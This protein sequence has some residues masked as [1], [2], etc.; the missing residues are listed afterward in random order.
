MGFQK[1]YIPWNKNM[2][3]YTNSGSFKK[4]NIPWN[5]GKKLPNWIRKKFSKSAIGKH[6]REKNPRWKG[7]RT[8]RNGY[9]YLLM[10]KHPFCDTL[11]YYAEHR[12]VIE[13]KLKR[14]LKSNEHTHHINGIKNDNRIENLMLFIS[15]SAHK[16]FEIN[17]IVKPKEIIFNGCQF[18]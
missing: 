16:R 18:Q 5:K 7:G 10:P 9:I 13:Q 15:N 6:I 12:F 4:N 3:N 1:G 11:G 2:K 8:I 14:F 17:K